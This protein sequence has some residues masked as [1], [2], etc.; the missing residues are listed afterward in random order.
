MKKYSSILVLLILLFGAISSYAEGLEEKVTYSINAYRDN[1]SAFII[2][3][4]LGIVKSIW[5]KFSISGNAGVDAITAATSSNESNTGPTEKSESYRSYAS[6]SGIYDDRQNSLTLGGYLSEENDYS[7][8]SL[9]MNYVRQLNNQNTSVGLT[10][11]SLSDRWDLKGLTRN[12]RKGRETNISISQFLSPTAQ[13]QLAYSNI[14]SSGFLASPYRFIE[15]VGPPTLIKEKLPDSRNG[16][17]YS[18]KLVKQLS[19]P[20][21]IN[22]AYRYYS[23]DWKITSHTINAELYRDMDE[24]Y[25]LGGRLRLYSQSDTA[26]TKD[27]TSYDG[28]EEYAPID[29]KYSAF[30]SYMLG[31]NVIYKIETEKLKSYVIKGSLD[32]YRT[33]DNDYIEFWYGNS[34]LDAII[35]SCSIDYLY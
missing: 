10:F 28:L 11:S 19:E 33:S 3:N 27:I 31:L 24:Y 8:R 14:Y 5:D 25:T 4:K 6:L 35:F 23:D 7:G 15:Q 1:S 20:T 26:Y 12:D 9:F 30:D 32:Y 21:S 16:D 18:L 34:N 13:L 17:A 22:I 29:Y 2:T